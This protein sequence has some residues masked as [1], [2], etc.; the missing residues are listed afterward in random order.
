MLAVAVWARYFEPDLGAGRCFGRSVA[1][2][3]LARHALL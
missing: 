2:Q 1:V 3:E